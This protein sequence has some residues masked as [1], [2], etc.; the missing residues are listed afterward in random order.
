[1][2]LAVGVQRGDALVVAQ[3]DDRAEHRD[4]GERERIA[5]APRREGMTC[6]SAEPE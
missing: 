1:M 3:L 6:R 2:P 5:R 4:A